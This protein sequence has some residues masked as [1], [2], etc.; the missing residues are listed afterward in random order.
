[1]KISS[2]APIEFETPYGSVRIVSKYRYD[3]KAYRIILYGQSSA[4]KWMLPNRDISVTV[5]GNFEAQVSHPTRILKTLAET[6]DFRLNLL[7]RWEQ[8][9]EL[10]QIGIHSSDGQPAK[11]SDLVERYLCSHKSQLRPRTFEGY[12]HN[13]SRWVPHLD[14][15]PLSQLNGDHIKM[16]LG[17]IAE[18]VSAITANG[19]LRVLRIIFSYAFREGYIQS[20]PHRRVKMLKV[21]K[22][23]ACWWTPD[24]AGKVLL[25]A[26]GDED[27]RTDA[28]LLFAVALY[29]GLRKGEIVRLKWEDISIDT[30]EPFVHVRSTEYDPT[31]TGARR[32]VPICAELREIL[33]RFRQPSGHV[34]RPERIEA[35]KWIY[36]FDPRA[37][38]RRVIKK[39]GVRRIRFHEMRH[40]FASIMLLKGVSIFSVSRWLGHEDVATTEEVYAHTRAYNPEINLMRLREAPEQVSQIVQPS[41]ATDDVDAPRVPASRVIQFPLPGRPA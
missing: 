21:I 19:A 37:I 4:L 10:E 13:L 24:E 35:G 30:A 34:L 5:A 33:L 26:E 32:F 1:V 12:R 41:P 7:Q 11:Y 16:G 22:R 2:L 29:L 3:K 27:A 40:T 31:K 17:S 18:Q 15:A 36:R 28:V 9:R 8:R 20:E 23:E 38:W 25:A 6:R 39:A 14:V